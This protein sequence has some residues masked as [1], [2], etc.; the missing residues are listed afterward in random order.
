MKQT[1][2]PVGK[3]AKAYESAEKDSVEHTI[4]IP[5]WSWA[6]AVKKLPQI[7][8]NHDAAHG[9]LIRHKTLA[10]GDGECNFWI[11]GA[12]EP[13]AVRDVGSK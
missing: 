12:Q 4:C 3:E 1:P 10:A 13:E 7:L 5:L 9:K 6:I 11:L 8:P 2:E